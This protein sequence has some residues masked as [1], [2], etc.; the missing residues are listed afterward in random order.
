M[1]GN[2]TE[3]CLDYYARNFYLAAKTEN[4][5][6][7]AASDYRVAR[8]GSWISLPQH[9]RSAYRSFIYPDNQYRYMGFRLVMAKAKPNSSRGHPSPRE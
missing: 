5:L 8:G 1:H 7:R 6:N 3:M 9:C 2:V 4:P